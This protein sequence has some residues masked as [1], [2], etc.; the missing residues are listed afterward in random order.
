MRSKRTA[1]AAAVLLSLLVSLPGPVR[2]H[3]E[4]ALH[5]LTVL[6]EVTPRIGGLEIRVTHVTAPAL[7]A[8]NETGKPLIVLGEKGEPFLRIGGGVVETNTLSPTS[9]RSADP[10]G[11]R[12]LPLEL[13]ATAPP[14]W[15]V[16]VRSNSWSWFDPRLR[17][18]RSGKVGTWHV[19]ARLGSRPITIEGGFE[20]LDGHGHFVSSLE[21]PGKGTSGMEVRLLE[22]PVPGIFV[23]NDTDKLL[24]IPGPDDEPFLRIGPQGVEANLRSPMYYLGGDQVIRKVPP[25]ADPSASPQWLKVS[26]IPVWAWLEWRARVPATSEQRAV[27][28]PE[29]RTV[30]EWDVPATLG[31]EPF[32]IAG[33]VDWV[34]PGIARGMD[35]DESSGDYSFY[36]VLAAAVAVAAGAMVVIGRRTRPSS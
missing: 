23:Q 9:Y 12:P 19:N 2:A 29:P 3:E 11:E 36:F 28:G 24:V 31:G 18:E 1:A 14:K 6:H 33:Q 34:P 17:F 26:D 8:T 35:G 15:S 25:E 10:T 4:R 13:D 21:A 27:L 30:L 20:S 5:S 32:P 22:G 16:L 7:I